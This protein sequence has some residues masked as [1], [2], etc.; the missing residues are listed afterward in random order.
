M[1][2]QTAVRSARLLPMTGTRG[3]RAP[4]IP[5]LL[6]LATVVTRW[7]FRTHYL[8]MWDSANF[9]LALDHYDVTQH[10]P[11]PPGYFFF[12]AV[13]RVLLPLAGDANTALVMEALIFSA[14]AVVALY[15][16][17]R[18][19]YGETVGLWAALLLLGSVTF[20]SFG[21]IALAYPSLAF[22]STLV[23]LLAYRVLCLKE[24][25][26][27]LLAGAY[28]L[29]G[30]FR[31]EL[32]LFLGPLF[33]LCLLRAPWRRSALAV[34]VA[35]LGC[36]LWLVPTVTL[37]GG[38]EAYLGVLSAYSGT[39]VLDR[40]SVLRRGLPALINNTGDTIAYTFYALYGT[41][42]LA[43]G[44]A[45][46]W[47]ARWRGSGADAQEAG[48]ERKLGFLVLWMAPMVL[49]YLIIHIGYAGYVFSFLP[50]LLLAL[51]RGWWLIPGKHS[52]GAGRNAVLWGG[53]A[54][55]LAVNA[56]VFVFHE[57]LLTAPGLQASDAAIAARLEL[58]RE[59]DPERT[60]L[61]S[62]DSLK[63]LDYYAPNYRQSI[64]VD[65]FSTQEQGHPV[66]PT[67]QY[68]LLVDSSLVAIA[69]D[70]PGTVI[71]LPGNERAMRVPLPVSDGP[72]FLVYRPGSLSLTTP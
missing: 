67:A 50:A 35:A 10:R 54:L 60:V 31:P 57:R 13:G 44:A 59:S 24:D 36:A 69:K 30:G 46:G 21:G 15:V 18:T 27:L 8:F 51:A 53:V 40:Y 56:Y 26:L 16:L 42:L 48:E 22:F 71:S 32:M 25:R 64:W 2:L 37:S 39:E 58:V 5:W 45:L 6:V 38:I 3:L 29:G 43:P 72:R 41:A 55:A 66:P 49:F 62:Y 23:A 34:G 33:G 70:L 1:V 12:V 9:A 7:P 17:A 19:M 28:S 68:A 14:L 11:H 52:W 65:I 4:W 47:I 20:W 63:H 61:V